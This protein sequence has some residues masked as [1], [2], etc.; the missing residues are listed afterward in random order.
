MQLLLLPLLSLRLVEP[1]LNVFEN[2]LLLS[3]FNTLISLVNLC[4]NALT[5]TQSNPLHAFS[6]A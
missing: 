3:S 6:S 2:P 4:A 1:W 5:E